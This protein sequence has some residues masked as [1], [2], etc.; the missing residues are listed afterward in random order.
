[1]NRSNKMMLKE[2]M[3]LDLKMYDLQL[4]LDTHPFESKAVME[5]NTTANKYMSMKQHYEKLYG[6]ITIN[7]K[8]DNT[9]PWQWIDSPWPWQY[10]NE[11]EETK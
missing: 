2:L 1:M 7:D 8:D 4:F 9:T 3:A 11:K 6:P 5:Y 10:Q